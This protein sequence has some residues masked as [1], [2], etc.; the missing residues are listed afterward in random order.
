MNSKLTSIPVEWWEFGDRG[1]HFAEYTPVGA[2]P[3]ILLENL[4][5]QARD[6]FSKSTARFAGTDTPNPVDCLRKVLSQTVFLINRERAL[7]PSD[8]ARFAASILEK[9]LM[10]GN[11]PLPTLGIERQAL[12]LNALSDSVE[13]ISSTEP[14]MGWYCDLVADAAGILRAVIDRDEFSLDPAFDYKVGRDNSVLGSEAEAKFIHNWVPDALG[15]SAGHWFI[16]QAPFG[17]LLKSGSIE[18]GKDARRVDFLFSYP[19]S[20]PIAIEI[21]GIQHKADALVDRSR[22][23]SLQSVGIKVIRITSSELDV[24]VGPILT[25]LKQELRKLFTAPTPTKTDQRLAKLLLSCSVAAKVQFAIAGALWR[26]WLRPGR[27]WNIRIRG[28]CSTST[29]G[30]VDLLDMLQA[31]EAVYGICASPTHC[32][33]ELEDGNVVDW[34]N[35]DSRTSGDQGPDSFAIVEETRKGPCHT[36]HNNNDSDC[37]IRSVYLP[38]DLAAAPKPP[39]KARYP[40]KKHNVQENSRIHRS[41]R[42]FLQHIYRKRDFREGQYKAL[43]NAIRHIDTIVLLPTGGGKSII[44]Q[45]AGLLMPGVTLVIDPLTS[46]MED[47]VEGL[48][49]Y[50]IDRTEAIY[51]QRDQRAEVTRRKISL[52][53]TG[54]YHFVFVSPERLQSP[55]FRRALESMVM[56]NPINMAVIDEAHC[57]SEWGHD[58]RPAYLSL[59]NSLRN[60]YSSDTDPGPPL[61]A[62]TGTASRAVLRDMINDLEIDKNNSDALIRPESFDRKEIKFRVIRTASGDVTPKLKEELR[63][64]PSSCGMPISEYYKPRG[65]K[66]NSGII[67]VPTVRGKNGIEEIAHEVGQTIPVEITLFSGRSPHRQLRNDSN[68]DQIKRNNASKFKQNEIPVLVA[69]KAYGMGIDKPNIRYTIHCGVPSSIEQYYQEAGRAGRD[70]KEAY[71]M[72]ILGEISERR[73]NALLNPDLSIEKLR[74][75][76]EEESRNYV[77]RDDITRALFF[78]L[79]GFQGIS[80]EIENAKELIWLI[81]RRPP[82]IPISVPFGMNQSQREKSIYRLYKLGFVKDYTVDFG[83]KLFQIITHIFDFQSFK[84]RFLEYVRS[85]APGKVGSSRRRIEAIEPTDHFDALVKL[86]T[87]FIEF[88]YDEIERAR[89]RAIQESILLARQ[90]KTDSEVRKRLLDYLQEGVGYEKINELILCEQVDL[91]A[92]LELTARI[93]NSIEA[94]E[95]RGLCIRALESSPDHPGLLLIRGVVETMASDYYWNVASTNIVRA[96]TVGIEK[97][98]ITPDHMEKTFERLFQQARESTASE[99]DAGQL[100]SALTIALLDVARK[101]ETSNCQFAENVAIRQRSQSNNLETLAILNWYSLDQLSGLLLDYSNTRVRKFLNIH[102]T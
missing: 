83:P 57:I 66:T 49:L 33:I 61:L 75:L 68:W 18:T 38:V 41:L 36:T 11:T 87:A 21:D 15:E 1:S 99:I 78:H 92:W 24:G 39:Y 12:Q 29:A 70:Q 76:H 46:L 59:T 2:I 72:L 98:D 73:S 100:E 96:V 32:L 45:L 20:P 25:S 30:V 90:S 64:L 79:Q 56:N 13:E 42:L 60:L 6:S 84:G 3:G 88:S 69:T 47:Q 55:T 34:S 81:I 86:I 5:Q 71:S 31:I 26:G 63:R 62:L 23:L 101:G 7:I 27:H 97:Y 28:A 58:F 16:P 9:L 44:Y 22:D 43:L 14:E 102:G 48:Q 17:P 89:R 4:S 37:I 91:L 54:L 53:E 82:M 50:G 74:E 94:G 51:Y 52:V 77:A 35:D 95:I 67:F 93:G 65:R 85:V 40:A 80:A 19:L 10:R 8:D